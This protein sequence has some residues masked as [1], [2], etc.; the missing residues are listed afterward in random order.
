MQWKTWGLFHTKSHTKCNYSFINKSLLPP[1]LQN[2]Y[3]FACSL[4]DSLREKSRDFVTIKK[5]LEAKLY[6]LFLPQIPVIA[7]E[8]RRNYRKEVPGW[9]S[10]D[11]YGWSLPELVIK[12]Y[13]ILNST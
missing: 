2:Y 5:D 4:K 1:F 9:S 7:L 12:P 8:K 13:K 3:H 6:S 10:M 11:K